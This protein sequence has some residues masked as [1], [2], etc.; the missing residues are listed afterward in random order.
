MAQPHRVGRRGRHRVDQGR[1]QIGLDRTV[2]VL[3]GHLEAL[4]QVVGAD[5]I[6]QR[7]VLEQD[8]GLRQQHRQHVAEGL[9][10]HNELHGLAVGHAHGIARIDLPARHALDAGAH[11]LGVIGRLEQR[12]RDDGGHL[13]AE[14]LADQ[15]G[16]QQEEPQDHHH[17][18]D[19]AQ[20]VH[21]ERR[22]PHQPGLGRQAHQGQDRADD[23]AA[24]HRDQRELDREDEALGDE[25]GDDAPVQETEVEIHR[26]P[27]IMP[28]MRSRLSMTSAMRLMAKAEMK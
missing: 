1:D 8:D 17:Q 15:Q 20:R 23:D 2:E 22:R 27:P 25:A 21:I 18:R 14:R 10:Q 9:R 24:D 3:A 16:N 7:G 26:P 28:G 11:D 4:E 6:D 12:E 13:R 5:G 19:G